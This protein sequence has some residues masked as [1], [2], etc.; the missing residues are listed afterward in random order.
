MK[1]AGEIIYT[2]SKCDPAPGKRRWRDDDTGFDVF[3]S[4]EQA[5]TDL[6]ELRETIVDDPDDTWSPMQ[7]EKIVLRPMT[8][9]NIL[10]LLN[11]GMEAVVLEHEVLEVVQ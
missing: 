8:R 3:D 10:T 4:F 2:Y 6:L 9:A 5:K 1:S 7:I 11:H